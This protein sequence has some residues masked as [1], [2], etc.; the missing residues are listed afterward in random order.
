MFTNWLNMGLL[1]WALI[2]KAVHGAALHW[3]SGKEKFPGA[4]V[5][6]GGHADSLLGHEKDSSLLISLKNVQ[7]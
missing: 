5:S 1:Q 2:E 4:V 6:K 3:L 7:L